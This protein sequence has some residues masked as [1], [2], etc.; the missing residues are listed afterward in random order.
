MI[1]SLILIIDFFRPLFI[2]L[3]WG[4]YTYSINTKVVGTRGK[5]NIVHRPKVCF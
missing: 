3:W 5:P 2:V 1:R 4:L